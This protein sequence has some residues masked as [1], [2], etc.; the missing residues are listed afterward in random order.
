MKLISWNVNGLR[1]VLGKGFL[2]YFKAQDADVFCLQEIKL[3]E[4]QL[5]LDLGG[6]HCY[7]NYAQKKGY[8]GTAVFSKKEPLSVSFGSD[9]EGRVCTLEFEDFYVVDV[10]TPNSQDELARLDFRLQWDADFREYV[11]ELDKKKTVLICG[12]MNV[13]HK[14]IDIKNPKTNLRNA[15]FTIEERQSFD[16]LLESGFTDTF[17]MFYP[18]LKDAYSWWSYR[19]KSRERNTGWRIDYWLVSTKSESRVK[20]AGIHSQILGS[21]HAPVYIIFE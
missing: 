13:A 5:D 2:D 19:F 11:K 3:S 21:D 4:G 8:S 14:E 1:A 10:Y 6:Y 7:Y 16:K 20:E 17:R 12:D 15:G 18:D 9:N